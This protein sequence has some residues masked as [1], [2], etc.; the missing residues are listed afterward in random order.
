MS[1]KGPPRGVD[2]IVSFAGLER[3]IGAAERKLVS[4]GTHPRRMQISQGI[5]AFAGMAIELAAAAIIRAASVAW[6]INDAWLPGTADVV[7]EMR[8]AINRCVSGESKRSPSDIKYHDGTDFHA[9]FPGF[10]PKTFVAMGF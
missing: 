3:N 5:A 9:G 2:R 6:E 1:G 8:S 10:S 4:G 7:A